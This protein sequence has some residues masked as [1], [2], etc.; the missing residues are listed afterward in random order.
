MS[1]GGK[2]GKGGRCIG[3]TTLPLHVT[4]A[5]K[6]GSLHLL[7]PSG[8][9]QTSNGIAFTEEITSEILNT[10]CTG[11]EFQISAAQPPRLLIMIYYFDMRFALRLEHDT[12]TFTLLGCY[13][14]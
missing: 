5:L 11:S 6:C 1:K 7:E 12:N 13:A 8:P 10:K 9:V 3:L 2:G 14:G 4:I